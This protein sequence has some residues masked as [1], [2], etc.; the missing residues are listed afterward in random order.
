ML[1]LRPRIHGAELDPEL[2]HGL[3][4]CVPV[5]KDVTDEA[6]REGPGTAIVLDRG[7][8]VEHPLIGRSATSMDLKK[9]VKRGRSIKWETDLKK[10]RSF[11]YER[12]HTRWI[13]E[14]GVNEQAASFEMRF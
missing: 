11:E 14:E 7:S 1:R 4:R 6:K 5:C 8:E 13:T 12:S 9:I 2:C 10:R 3:G